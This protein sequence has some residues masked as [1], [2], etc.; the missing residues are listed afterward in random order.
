MSSDKLRKEEKL[1]SEK[2]GQGEKCVHKNIDRKVCV[3]PNVE[4]ERNCVQRNIDSYLS[5]LTKLDRWRCCGPLK[6][7]RG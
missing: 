4:R 3:E 6:R 1:F 7:E 5:V 2:P